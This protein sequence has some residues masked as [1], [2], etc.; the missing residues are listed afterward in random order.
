M[1]SFKS[2]ENINKK[3]EGVYVTFEHSNIGNRIQMTF[4]KNDTLRDTLGQFVV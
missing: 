2:N 3:K 1:N 4:H